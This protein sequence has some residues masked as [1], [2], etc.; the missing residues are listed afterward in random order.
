[1]FM[2]SVTDHS[3]GKHRPRWRDG[4]VKPRPV[5]A[6]FEAT[7]AEIGRLECEAHYRVGRLVIDHW[8]EHCAIGK[9]ALIRARAEYVAKNNGRIGRDGVTRYGRETVDAWRSQRITRRDM[10][11]ILSRSFPVED[12]R[13]ISDEIASAAAQHL[14]IRRNGGFFVSPTGEGDWWVGLG[15]KS[16]AELLDLAKARGFDPASLTGLDG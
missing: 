16:S 13:I 3:S 10:G 7:F 14:R 9:A 1:M 6:D 11:K 8:L 12:R 15:R 4:L 2:D 5:P